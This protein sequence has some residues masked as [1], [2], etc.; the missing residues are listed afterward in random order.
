MGGRLQSGPNSHDDL[1]SSHQVS[2]PLFVGDLADDM[3]TA[4]QE[5]SKEGI[6]HSLFVQ[7]EEH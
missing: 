7:R 4:V 1:S 6:S 5:G 2:I 3:P